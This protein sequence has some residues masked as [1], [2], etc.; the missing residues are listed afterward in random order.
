M[1]SSPLT[2]PH[3]RK[4]P[5]AAKKI[6]PEPSPG[7][8][9]P[10]PIYD[11][12]QGCAPTRGPPTMKDTYPPDDREDAPDSRRTPP[13]AAPRPR[14]APL[15]PAAA[16][17]VLVAPVRQPCTSPAG[18]TSAPGRA[19]RAAG[20]PP[21]TKGRPL[22]DRAG[23]GQL[24]TCCDRAGNLGFLAK[25]PRRCGCSAT[26]AGCW[27]APSRPN[28]TARRPGARRCRSRGPQMVEGNHGLKKPGGRP[29]PQ[30][31]LHRRGGDAAG[32]AGQRGAGGVPH[33]PG[34]AVRRRAGRAA[35]PGDEP[36]PGLVALAALPDPPERRPAEGAEGGGVQPVDRAAG[37]RP[38][39]AGSPSTR[40]RRSSASAAART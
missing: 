13:R 33:A 31:R 22:P 25:R 37:E 15:G 26:A 34:R 23:G 29:D 32:D 14:P 36:P 3:D 10:R 28:R 6:S 1:V 18:C 38:P 4:F 27:S 24:R 20:T 7:P 9:A 35:A 21:R 12:E 40:A 39:A 30:G 8:P 2:R 16:L 11:S 17:A 5:P 19:G